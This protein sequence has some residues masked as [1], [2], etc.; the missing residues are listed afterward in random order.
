MDARR[1]LGLYEELGRFRVP[2][3]AYITAGGLRP[4][5]LSCGAGSRLP[6]AGAGQ[7]RSQLLR[8]HA[9]RATSEAHEANTETTRTHR[10][11]SGAPAAQG[12]MATTPTSPADSFIVSDSDSGDDDSVWAMDLDDDDAAAADTPVVRR[13]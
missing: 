2:A 3:A 9:S 1:T 7:R 12:S 10:T 13:R 5:G 8:P 4:A 6:P 11:G